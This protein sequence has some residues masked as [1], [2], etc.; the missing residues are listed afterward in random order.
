M[1]QTLRALADGGLI[2][3][4]DY[5]FAAVLG[6]LGEGSAAVLL[7]A[8]LASA[9][10]GRGDVC[11]ELRG[12]A[13]R[14]LGDTDLEAPTLA[15]WTA[16]LGASPRVGAG[17]RPTPLVLDAAGRLYLGRYHAFETA[18]A[19]WVRRRAAMPSPAV[20]PESL[21]REL[22]RLFPPS[23]DGEPDHQREAAVVALLHPFCVVS[24]GPGTGKTSTVIRILALLLRLLGPLRIALAA[25]T[26][27]AAARLGEALRA[28]RD[29]LGLEVELAP[30]IPDQVVTL[31]RL[32]G[33]RGDGGRPRHHA[34]NPLHCDLLVV[35]EASMVDL[36]LMARLVQALRPQA[37]L[38]LLGDRDQLASVEAGSVLGDICTG[39]GSGFTPAQGRLLQQVCGAAPGVDPEAPPLADT[40]CLLRHSYRFPAGSGIGRLAGAVN[41]GEGEAALACLHGAQGEDLA[42]WPLA[43]EPDL[44]PLVALAA[45]AYADYPRAQD[46][47]AALRAFNRFR[48]LCA[49][50]E[51]PYG[52]RALNRH[53]R[54]ELARRGLLDPQRDF[55]P[56]CPLMITRNDYGLRLFNGDVGLVWPDP[57]A[58]GALRAFFPSPEGELRAHT[59]SRLPAHE[60]V[61]AMTVHKS[62]GSEFQR[63]LLLLPPDPS[64][65]VTRE[66]VYTGLTRA[67]QRVELAA[68]DQA[69]VRALGQRN[70]RA[71]GLRERLWG[72][73]VP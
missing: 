15:T 3:P 2:R 19:D 47:A 20:A 68:S 57:A 26:G 22:D 1:L 9:A 50:R 25:P 31:H 16:A 8:A 36:P 12:L 58:D 40:L 37:R 61:L 44:G 41:A 63:V 29:G 39:A 66:L 54:A 45:E 69:L 23:G 35:D 42:G 10:L 5:H 11:L 14:P 60:T 71:S 43:R 64:P 73:P 28:R 38:I 70:R 34:D 7:G 27:K 65:V 46:P 49:L 72:A 52:V 62:Q 51:G 4:L 6:E 17:D 56:G 32:L 53:I 48:V 18:L 67:M 33:L 13:G 24:G 55:Y 59:L 21:A 30:L